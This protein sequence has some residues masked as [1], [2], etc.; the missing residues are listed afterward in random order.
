MAPAPCCINDRSGKVHN[1]LEPGSADV[2][3]HQRVLSGAVAGSNPRLQASS[4]I[5]SG[6]ILAKGILHNPFCRL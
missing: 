4:L 3:D 1:G 5:A 2:E 6:I